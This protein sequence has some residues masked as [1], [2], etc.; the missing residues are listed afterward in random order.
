MQADPRLGS[1]IAGHR[2]EAVIGRG[3][4][5]TVY[6]ARHLRLGRRV[7]LKVLDPALS[8]DPTFRE[9]FLREGRLAAS[10]D[11][12]NV[13]TVYDAGE[14]DGVL[15]V[16]MR[17]V[18]GTDLERLIASE[19]ALEPARAVAIVTQVAAA[20][21]AAHALG[22]VHRGIVPGDILVESSSD[23]ERVFLTDFGITKH[24]AA[25]T[26]VTRTGSFA[27]AVDHVAPELIRGTDAVDRR[28]D[29]YSLGCVLFHALVGRPPFARDSELVT[30]YAHLEDP[31]PRPS[32]ERPGLPAA[33]DPVVERALA[34]RPADRYPTCGALAADADRAL[35]SGGADGATPH[36][37]AEH[38]R[39]A[40]RPRMAAVVAGIG[41]AVAVLIVGGSILAIDGDGGTSPTS[42]PTSAPPDASPQPP[43]LQSDVL[44]AAVGEIACNAPPYVEGDLDHCRYDDTAALVDPGALDA[45]LALGD[46]Q[47]DAG[48]SEEYAAYYDPY[49]GDLR[50][51]T[52]PVP[53]DREHANDPTSRPSGYF[54]YFGD[55]V[56]G[57]EGLGSYSF[58]LP[59]GCSPEASTCW[60]IVALNSERCLLPEGCGPGTATY[61]WLEGDL[62]TH[63][64]DRYPCMLAYWHHPLHSF[65][66]DGSA[67][68]EVRPLW[69]LLD[70]AGADVVLNA[71]AHNYQRWAPVDADGA[72]D[73]DGMV[74]FVVGTGGSRK[75]SLAFGTFP[76]G[77]AAAQDSTFGVLLV[78][79]EVGSFTW[80][81]V[82][83]EGQP[84][85]EDGSTAAVDC[86]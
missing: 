83:A 2:I 39:T 68:P 44:I 25:A 8:D 47:Y 75:D 84:A 9:T 20:L 65:A 16:A 10:L 5:A 78:G 82:S 53:G 35:G 23:G 43:A 30:I 13:V 12:P 72:P 40:S 11:H 85:Y 33:L 50:P 61:A 4:L 26:R 52:K 63:P 24:V 28:A 34:K 70:A 66:N 19:G 59:A 36:A 45:F 22:L 48:T 49:W 55:A 27:G 56:R 37:V 58:D 21:D 71:N 41:A 64:N 46:T 38:A 81:W 42:I 15:F 1:E 14:S 3:R 51:I 79:L 7:A 32:E 80:R 29:V 18:D 57:H 69:E 54:R 86:A 76:E 6:L 62:R 74:Q 77:L 17:Y 73:A 31:P 60:H 67:T